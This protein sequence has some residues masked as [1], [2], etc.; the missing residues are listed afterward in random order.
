MVGSWLVERRD[1][2]TAPDIRCDAIGVT[3]DGAGRLIAIEHLEG[4]F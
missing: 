2:P 4:A 1:H 3:L